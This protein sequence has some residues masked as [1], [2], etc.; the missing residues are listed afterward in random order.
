MCGLARLP[1]PYT[2]IATLVISG[3][4]LVVLVLGAR[5]GYQSAVESL[6]ALS[7][8]KPSVQSTASLPPAVP[9]SPIT[10]AT[11]ALAIYI[12]VVVT[13]LLSRFLR[14]RWTFAV[15]L[16]VP[17][18]VFTSGAIISG[19][20]AA[21]LTACA[22]VA[23]AWMAGDVILLLL[24]VP[25][26][27]IPQSALTSLRVALGLGCLGLTILVLGSVNG[28]SLL[29][30][31]TLAILIALVWLMSTSRNPAR[32][33]RPNLPSSWAVPRLSWFESLMMALSAALFVFAALAALTP[34]S[35]LT[36]S[37]SVRQH[38]PQAREIWQDHAVL[39]YPTIE[40]PS[41]SVLGAALNA[42]AFG[43]GDITAVRILQVLVSLCCLIAIAGL[44][45]TLEGNT[46]G[47]V[48]AAIFSATPLVLWLTGHAYPDLLAVLFVCGSLQC[49]ICWQHDG[50]WV[51][52]LL[53]GALGGFSLAT[54][55]ISAVVIV[56]ILVALVITARP[57]ISLAGRAR[58]VVM[59][60]VACLLVL[61]PWFVRSA[62][63]TGTFPLL[64][65][66][67]RQLLNV[68]GL[69]NLVSWLPLSAI[70]QGPVVPP[71]GLAGVTGGV[72]RSLPGILAGPWDLTFTGA[73]A[74]FQVVRHGEFGILL[75]LFLPLALLSICTRGTAL[76]AV[77][78]FL[79]Y[80]GWIFTIQV[81]RHLLP[82][83]ALLAV[84]AGVAVARTISGSPAWSRIPLGRFAQ[85]AAVVG[86][87]LTPLF[88]L[89][90]TTTGF[91]I[92][93][94]TGAT[95]PEAYL[96]RVDPATP[97]LSAASRLL[98][99]DTPV[100]YIGQWQGAQISTESRL[101]YLG[102]YSTDPTISLD[103]QVGSTPEAIFRSFDKWGIQYFIWD[104]P[105][106]RPQDVGSTLL[107]GDFLLRYTTILGGDN[108]VYLFEIHPDGVADP[109]S[110]VNMLQDPEFATLRAAGNVWNGSKRDV[111][112]AGR[113]E[114]RRQ[115]AVVQRVDVLPGTPYLVVL[116]GS[117]SSNLDLTRVTLNWLDANQATISTTSDDLASGTGINSTLM[118]R[119]SPA[120]AAAVNVSVSTAAGSPCQIAN[121]GMYDYRNS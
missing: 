120:N 37:D 19:S 115:V 104:R 116:T 106:T 67:V 112:E 38:L 119:A 1:V 73:Y 50:Q 42:V 101:I 117:C 61:V 35:I 29:P 41:A 36:G 58:T 3:W 40:T 62:V 11:A 114:P 99:A 108:G 66:I 30:M 74:N 103:D 14:S 24:R 91:P 81:P 84:L 47:I 17:V 70:S 100:G 4:M 31:V 28:I 88:F 76:L 8:T 96:S 45:S 121:I 63:L 7:S 90:N 72:A 44:G 83:L 68:P 43:F 49:I 98:P 69:R 86:I 93:V 79:S 59:F 34:E 51:W 78:A 26:S 111:G 2:R 13:I 105:D 55:Q 71:D 80:L 6:T 33:F 39:V 9:D 56:A 10:Y 53:S 89:P 5:M 113:F 16:F 52:L 54:K 18:A 20:I 27:Q 107:S 85:I 64:G 109:T 110:Q 60:S 65:T 48:G 75:L 92:T 97:A 94:L 25:T 23:T 32:S 118:W 82:G 21:A 12:V 87:A 22:V 57:G 46:A 95:R 102:Q 15:A 77:V